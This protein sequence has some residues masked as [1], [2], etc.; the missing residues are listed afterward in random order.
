MLSITRKWGRYQISATPFRLI[1]LFS[2]FLL[3]LLTLEMNQIN[4]IELNQKRTFVI[5]SLAKS[6]YFHLWK[7]V[8]HLNFTSTV[9]ESWTQMWMCVAGTVEVRKEGLEAQINRL[10]E[11]IGRLENKVKIAL[12][13]HSIYQYL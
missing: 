4:W 12:Y 7:C 3:V 11:L 13:T 2:F 8:V 9:Q 1:C 6:E 5:I 10:A